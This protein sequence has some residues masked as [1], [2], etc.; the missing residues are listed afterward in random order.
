M[1]PRVRL[2]NQ[3]LPSR[4]FLIRHGESI[5]N[6]DSSVYSH[7]PDWRIP[8]TDLGLT[9]AE[10]CGKDLKSIIGDQR[11]YF[12]GSPYM[13]AQQTLNKIAAHFDDN[14]VEGVREDAR[15]REQEMGNFQPVEDMKRV[16]GERSK[17][18]RFFFRFPGGESGADVCDRA[19][20]FMDSLFREREMADDCAENVVIVF[21]GLMMRL[22]IARWYKLPL[23]M[24]DAMYNP[25][26]GKVLLMERDETMKKLILTKESQD[27]L[28]MKEVKD[29]ALDGAD[30]VDYYLNKLAK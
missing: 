17:Q 23:E 14:Q 8:L 12:Y 20:S 2:P 9:Q 25:P 11:V 27:L 6:V 5:A 1:P 3:Y 16:W 30:M 4:L 13:R 15:L 21:H 28:G 22:F 18:G 26:N 10:E 7:T 29:T 19:S 24:F